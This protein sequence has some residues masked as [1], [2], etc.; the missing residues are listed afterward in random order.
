MRGRSSPCRD[1]VSGDRFDAEVGMYRIR[2][3]R[4]AAS[5]MFHADSAAVIRFLSAAPVGNEDPPAQP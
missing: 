5:Q 3:G 4:V 2:D 1:R